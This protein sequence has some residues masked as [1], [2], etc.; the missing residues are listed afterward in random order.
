MK[1]WM[2]WGEADLQDY[3]I[4]KHLLFDVVAVTPDRELTRFEKLF[5][6]RNAGVPTHKGYLDKIYKSCCCFEELKAA[7]SVGLTSRDRGDLA[8]AKGN[9]DH[10][11]QCYGE[12]RDPK[13]PDRTGPHT[14]RLLRLAFVQEKWEL[15]VRRFITTGFMRGLTPGTVVPEAFEVSG[16]L[17]LRILGVALNRLGVEVPSDARSILERVFDCRLEEFNRMRQHP[18]WNERDAIEKLKKRIAPR[19]KKFVPMSVEQALGLGNTPRANDVLR[20]LLECDH[21]VN[22]SQAQLQEFGESGD[23]ETLRRFIEI[24][25]ASGV[26]SASHTFLFAAMGH[27]SFDRTGLSPERLIRLY[28]S[29]PIMNKRHFGKLLDLKFRHAIPVTGQEIL[30]GLFQQRGSLSSII[31]PDRHPTFFSV[32]KLAQVEEWA[33]ARL[34]DWVDKEGASETA[35]VAKVWRAGVAKPVKHLFGGDA[36]RA[37]DT[38]RNMA[39][40]NVLLNSAAQWLEERWVEEIGTTNWISENQ[41]YQLL[42]RQLKNHTVIQ[43]A[44]PAW[45]AP[46]HLDVFVPDA[47]VAIEFMGEQHYRPVDFFGGQRAFAEIQRRDA[48]KARLCRE[49]GVELHFVRFDENLAQRIREIIEISKID[50][51]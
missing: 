37:P 4:R 16:S 14:D 12:V 7:G 29:H 50:N 48:E 26:T 13:H 21:L 5:V 32:A 3:S 18:E 51:H 43:H 41:L 44:Q 35:V 17:F 28:N 1:V 20:F 2:G 46:Q 40:W 23:E 42:K 11:E 33:A 22:E 38:P 27:D 25:T 6:A 30:T 10:A 19:A 45:L 47:A 8:W 9:L 24:V 39:E 49:F 36:L 31:N 34:S 15:V